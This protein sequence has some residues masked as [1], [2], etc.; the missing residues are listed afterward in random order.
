MNRT[1]TSTLSE[2][3][4][5]NFIAYHE[6]DDHSSLTFFLPSKRQEDYM[7]P[8]VSITIKG[9]S[10]IHKLYLLLMRLDKKYDFDSRFLTFKNSQVTTL[11]RVD[12]PLLYVVSN[13]R[14]LT[15]VEP[16][17]VLPTGYKPTK[18]LVFDI[19][20]IGSLY[21]L[22]Q[23]VFGIPISM[24]SKYVKDDDKDP[25]SKEVKNTGW[26]MIK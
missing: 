22:L 6:L 3:T 15:F 17:Q 23:H 18:E 11:S 21:N 26:Q 5:A 12:E 19:D 16:D 4:K 24:R 1:F 14:G 9:E 7:L 13:S 25:K 2:R 10:S 8:P 20:K